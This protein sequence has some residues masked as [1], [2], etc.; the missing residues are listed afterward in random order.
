[1]GRMKALGVLGFDW[2]GLGLGAKSSAGSNEGDGEEDTVDE[3]ASAAVDVDGAADDVDGVP[4]A[5]DGKLSMTGWMLHGSTQGIVTRT[6][7]TANHV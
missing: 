2:C 3:G 1:M 4:G 5:V 6:K 7:T